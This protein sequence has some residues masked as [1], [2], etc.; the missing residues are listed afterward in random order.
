MYFILFL[1]ASVA[2]MISS[3]NWGAERDRYGSNYDIT[4]ASAVSKLIFYLQKLE[5]E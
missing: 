5:Q 3:I 4:Q 1:T 2:V